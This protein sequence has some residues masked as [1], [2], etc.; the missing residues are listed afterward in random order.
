M[1]VAGIPFKR[2]EQYDS[3]KVQR[4]TEAVH[5]DLTDVDSRLRK[6]EKRSTVPVHDFGDMPSTPNPGNLQNFTF[7]RWSVGGTATLG[8]VLDG[9]VKTLTLS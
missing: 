2:D 1:K 5:E 6:T 4:F 7:V 9:Q 3:V 8:I